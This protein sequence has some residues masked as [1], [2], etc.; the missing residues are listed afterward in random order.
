MQNIS[1]LNSVIGP[2]MRGPSSSHSAGPYQIANTVRQLAAG[3]GEQIHSVSIRFDP[4]GSFATM[5]TTQGSDEG[6][7]AGFLGIPLTDEAY[8][9][10]LRRFQSGE[11]YPLTFEVAPLDPNDHPNRVRIEVQVTEAD[12]NVRSDRFH[13]VSTGGGMFIIDGLNEHAI[14]VTGSEYVVLME[15]DAEV[16][17]DALAGQGLG[18]PPA[19]HTSAG[20]SQFTSI[21]ASPEA[22]LTNIA[23][24]AR[25]FPLYPDLK[26]LAA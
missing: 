17:S 14:E 10:A 22:A 23:V 5:Y 8:R 4:S 6:S 12:G 20:I 2:I 7:A 3:P 25:K 18:W 16:I 13:A 1:L 24:L 21:A 19:A 15:G 26:G 11:S 9:D